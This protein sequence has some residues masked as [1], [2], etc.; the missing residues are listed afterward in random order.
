M[1]SYIPI[2]SHYEKYFTCKNTS[3]FLRKFSYE[4][5]TL[6]FIPIHK[7]VRVVS[8]KSVKFMKHKREIN[9]KEMVKS[10]HWFASNRP[11]CY[12]LMTVIAEKK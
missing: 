2:V 10:R 12:G 5:K 9:R 6:N 4:V 11:H 7:N 3:E 1:R 8:K